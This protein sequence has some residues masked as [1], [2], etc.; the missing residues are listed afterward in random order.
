MYPRINVSILITAY[1]LYYIH[2]NRGSK[3]MYINASF[4]HYMDTEAV[5]WLLI[6]VEGPLS[7]MLTLTVRPSSFHF[8]FF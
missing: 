4:I 1:T 8:D 6:S 7:V 5:P 2:N 3:I